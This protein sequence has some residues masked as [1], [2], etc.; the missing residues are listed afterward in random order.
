MKFP[1]P[2]R[3]GE[4]I[5]IIPDVPHGLK[6]LRTNLF[7]HGVQFEYEGKT[8]FFEKKHFEELFEADQ[9]GELRMC[10]KIK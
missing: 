10:P 4:F 7:Q 9:L 6:N 1:H 8:Y 2:S 5:A 3:P